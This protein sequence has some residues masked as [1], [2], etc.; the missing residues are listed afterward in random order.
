MSQ[1]H[2]EIYQ[3]SGLLRIRDLG[4]T[5]GTYI[6]RRPVTTD[7]VLLEGDILHVA[8][9]EFVIARAT[10]HEFEDFMG[11]TAEVELGLPEPLVDQVRRMRE[12]LDSGEVQPVFQPIVSLDDESILG[13]EM[14]GRADVE[15]LPAG[16][17][18]LFNVAASIGAEAELSRLFRLACVD[19]CKGLPGKPA[20][21]L[22]PHPA[23]LNA[24]GLLDSLRELR[25]SLPKVELVLE[26]HEVAITEPRMIRRLRS[27]LSE[28][29]IGLAYDDFGTGQARL[30]DVVEVPPDYLKFDIS[31]IRGIDRLVSKQR[32]LESLVGM[33]VE[34][35]I[36]P[37]AEG[38]ETAEEADVCRQ[39]GFQ[40]GQ[41]YLLGRPLKV[42]DMRLVG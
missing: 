20:V 14:L 33:V 34:L 23:E 28:L 27:R 9:L 10:R 35:G 17:Y 39:L 38:I 12:L 31:L 21:F 16:A 2:A 29:D 41:G 40:Y 37:A 15:G 5:N 18:E 8:D 32:M 36:V 7:V 22:N 25:D 6:N 13:Y 19:A 30:V 4:S 11:K 42:E 26:I 1:E 3:V 24:P